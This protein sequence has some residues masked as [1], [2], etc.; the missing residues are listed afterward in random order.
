MRRGVQRYIIRSARPKEAHRYRVIQLAA[1][2]VGILFAMVAWPAPNHSVSWWI[3][4]ALAGACLLAV[5]MASQLEQIAKGVTLEATRRGVRITPRL[6]GW[7]FAGARW[8]DA[9]PF[10]VEVAGRDGERACVCY[11]KGARVL[12]CGERSIAGLA[13]DVDVDD[14]ARW[15]NDRSLAWRP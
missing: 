14:L 8:T 10:S 4:W 15:L 11:M 13:V 7:S 9:G 2:L 12:V 3:L 6:E 5:W 1:I